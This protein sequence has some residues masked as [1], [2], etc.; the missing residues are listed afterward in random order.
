[1]KLFNGLILVYKSVKH[2]NKIANINI[3]DLI[4][5]NFG[6]AC[7]VYKG[8]FGEP[9]IDNDL[10]TVYKNICNDHPF[11]KKIK[12]FQQIV[13]RF[14]FDVLIS[15]SNEGIYIKIMLIPRN[16][17]RDYM[18]ARALG[19]EYPEIINLYKSLGGNII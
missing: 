18:F 16:D 9:T 14:G 8:F 15:K 19:K 1:M 17:V 10:L 5:D 6:S 11:D 2:R 4:R 12:D 13:Y 7:A 3:N